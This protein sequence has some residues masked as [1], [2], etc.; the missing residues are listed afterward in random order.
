MND[1]LIVT[2]SILHSDELSRSTWFVDLILMK[3]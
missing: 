1:I 2:Y 3:L